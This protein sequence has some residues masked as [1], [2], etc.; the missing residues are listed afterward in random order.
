MDFLVLT[1][2]NRICLY[3]IYYRTIIQGL[4]EFDTNHEMALCTL[5]LKH[6]LKEKKLV[7]NILFYSKICQVSENNHFV[8][9]SF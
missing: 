1:L 9:L 2:L 3:Y 8:G 4:L 5:F 7:G 6:I